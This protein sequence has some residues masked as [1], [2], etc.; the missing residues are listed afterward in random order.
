MARLNR[1]LLTTAASLLLMAQQYPVWAAADERTGALE[2]AVEENRGDANLRLRL[3]EAYSSAGRTEE[4]I[5]QYRNSNR[6]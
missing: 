6:G 3:A 2:R 1:F 5:E 4:A